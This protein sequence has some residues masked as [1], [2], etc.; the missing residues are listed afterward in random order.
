MG[1]LDQTA[2][3]SVSRR[4]FVKAGA[5]AAAATALSG[6]LAACS[7]QS[8]NAVD[9]AETG[10]ASANPEEGAVWQPVACWLGCGTAACRNMGLVKDGIVLRQKSDDSHE[11]SVEHPQRAAACAVA[12]SASTCSP[13]IASSTP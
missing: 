5:A 4:G 7:P 3:T 11:D 10:D 6:A 1:Y 8:E 13:P 9:L 2:R 12:R